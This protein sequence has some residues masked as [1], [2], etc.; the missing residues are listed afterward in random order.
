MIVLASASPRRKQLLGEIT[1]KFR[2][3]ESSYTEENGLQLSPKQLVAY[4]AEHKAISVY[5]N[6]T[7]DAVI[8]A[9]TIVVLD[10]KILGKPHSV[11]EAEAM[12]QSLSDR[13]HIVHTGVCICY[14]GKRLTS[15][16]TSNVKFF[17]LTKE[18]INAYIQTN[19]PFDKA[20][21]YGVQDSGFVEEIIGSY[22][23]VM[24]FPKER[25]I[26]MLKKMEIAI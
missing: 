12:L 16:T 15:V 23:N 1:D 6:H 8:G 2:V 24:G 14:M 21:G 19:S 3:E 20:G 10:D 18:Q 9:D 5:K 22:S 26:K 4:L 11:E 25:V 13:E 17:P 7:K